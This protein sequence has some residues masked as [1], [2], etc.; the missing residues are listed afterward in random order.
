MEV[1]QMRDNLAARYPGWDKKLHKMPDN[2]I[3]AIYGRLQRTKA[4][5]Q[6]AKYTGAGLLGYKPPT[7]YV[8]ECHRC[9]RWFVSENPNLE[10]CRYC[11]TS[12]DDMNVR[13]V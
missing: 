6:P 9:Y 1:W 10:E 8:Y 7:H 2:Q 11:G 4:V 12:R 3:I 5:E 13:P